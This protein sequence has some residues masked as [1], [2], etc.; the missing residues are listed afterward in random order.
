MVAW[1]RLAELNFSRDRTVFDDAARRLTWS[2]W[3][4]L[5]RTGGTVAYDEVTSVTVETMSGSETVPSAR[6][7]IH[8]ATDKIPLTGMYSASLDQWEPVATRIPARH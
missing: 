5:G 7:A 1:E 4:P 8:T 6:V 3:T 2:K